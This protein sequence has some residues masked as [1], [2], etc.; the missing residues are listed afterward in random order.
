MPDPVEHTG[1]KKRLKEQIHELEEQIKDLVAGE[2]IQYDLQIRLDQQVKNQS[3]LVKLGQQ[4][5]KARDEAE[6]GALLVETLVE[7]LGYE[8]AVVCRW[9]SSREK[10]K[11]L[12]VEGYYETVEAEAVLAA[13]PEVSENIALKD[14]KDIDIDLKPSIPCLEMDERV[15]IACISAQGEY[16]AY[17]FFGNKQEKVMFNRKIDASDRALWEAL[18]SLATTAF[19][20][21]GLYNRLEKEQE[22]L[23]KTRDNLKNLNEEL[24]EIVLNRTRELA[25]SKDEYRA[26]YLASAR[27]SELYRTLLD[28]SPDPIVVYDINGF[29]TYINPAFTDVFGWEL[30]ELEGRKIDF[31]PPESRQET[32]EMIEL[33]LRGEG[34]TNRETRR[35]TKDGRII[36]VSISGAT[37]RDEKGQIAG[38]IINLRDITEKKIMEEEL[39][40]IRKLKSVGVLAGGIAHDFNNILAGILMNAQ[41]ALL[42]YARRQ[43][44]S[45]YLS[46]IEE[47][48][49]SAITLTSQ[50]LTFAKGGEPIMKPMHI[51]QV[52][53]NWADFASRGSGAKCEFDIADDLLPVEIDEGQMSQVIHNLIHNAEQAMSEGGIIT[54]SARN[55]IISRSSTKTPPIPSLGEHYIE[56]SIKDRGHGI[57]A[58]NIPK[59]FDPYFTTKK[60]GSGLGLA[61]TYSIIQKH[62]GTITV[63]SEVGK[64][65]EFLIFLPITEKAVRET[66]IPEEKKNRIV[67]ATGRILIMEDEEM[68]RETLVEVLTAAG[69]DVESVS[70]GEQAVDVYQRALSAGTRFDAVIMDLTISGGM[71]GKQTI[72]KL[73]KVDP[74]VRAIV[75]SGYSND[76]IMSNYREYGFA[77]VLAKPYKIED[78]NKLLSRILSG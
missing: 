76:P 3:E 31:V 29:P 68:L 74:N 15:I 50:L 28:A 57:P 35:Y 4:L 37:F 52:I 53:R 6:I 78:V 75:S 66:E 63:T 25:E 10:L 77:G 41:M 64:G 11:S 58:E 5:Q 16:L 47:A 49:Q 54:V 38:S 17:I 51:G 71:G 45:K 7:N 9:D 60:N 22:R 30:I 44:I 20:N 72:E 55:L 12:A 23:R 43:D 21:V 69:Y 70:D 36:N 46:G 67:S 65:T 33:V 18:S 2:L 8:K 73:L 32:D 61:T 1:E 34:F 39:L 40:K 62:K 26:L 19:E 59:I 14:I 42:K 56:I 27:T 48:T 13:V 24:E